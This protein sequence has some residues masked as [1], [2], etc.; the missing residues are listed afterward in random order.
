MVTVI[1]PHLATGLRHDIPIIAQ[2]IGCLPCEPLYQ[3]DRELN[4]RSQTGKSL[5]RIS[6]AL[7]VG[8][9]SPIRSRLRSL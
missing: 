6:T 2:S 4:Q 7:E 5:L 9:S 3:A 8:L 1:T